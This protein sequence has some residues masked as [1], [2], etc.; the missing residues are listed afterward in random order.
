MQ[1]KT[2]RSFL[3]SSAAAA[4]A[5]MFAV[6]AIAKSAASAN[7]RIRVAVVG[8]GDRSRYHIE[9][10]HKLATRNVELVALCD[11]DEN[12]LRAAA[13]R[14]EALAG[15]TIRT[16]TEQ[17]KLFDDK[18]IDAVSFA[19]P[20]H[21]HALQT[22]WACQ[23]GKDVYLEKPGTHNLLEGRQLCEAVQVRTDGSARHPTSLKPQDPRW[24][25]QASGRTDRRRLH[26][27]RD[28]VQ[29]PQ[30]AG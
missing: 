6:P 21:W 19:T 30:P 14:Y 13:A 23:A 20:D 10:L 29:I 26:G 7:D 1:T 22:I 2:R 3:I 9:A 4:G 18:S 27:T 25:P 16:E 28:F 12:N 17:R 5:S 24:R 11:C 8:T 15:E